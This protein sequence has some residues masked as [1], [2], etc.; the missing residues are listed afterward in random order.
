VSS[1]P[2]RKNTAAPPATVKTLV[3]AVHSRLSRARVAFGH[4]TTNAWDEA[5]YLVLHALRLPLDDLAP[6][7]E[8]KVSS[9]GRRR[10][11]RLVD[12]RIRRRVPA[13]YLT[14]EA[15]LGDYRFYVDAR[16]LV[17]RSFIAELLRERLQPWLARRRILRA[18]DLCTGSGC[19]AVILA[20]VFPS[21]YVDA[22]DISR[23]ALAV[24]RRNV[25]AYRLQRRVRVLRSDMFSALRGE[26]Y[27]LIIANPPYVS[28]N[29]M[30]KLPRE[31]RHEPRVALA[32]GKD[33]FDLLRV[34]LRE[35]AQHL[36]AGGLLVVEVGHKRK[37]IERL[38]PHLAFAWP[39]TSGGDDCVFMLVRGDLT[40]AARAATE[41]PLRA[42]RA[43]GGSRRR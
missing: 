28:A 20:T 27:D 33:G 40:G 25:N 19:L 29:V 4:G 30:R 5:V 14:R 8:Y 12:A 37:Q 32:G 1:Q 6:V 15:W 7:L 24:A 31:Y 36:T 13:A 42:S 26:R 34:I 22:V 9:A 35:S 41:A 21:A 3:D 2:R 39:Q 23:P 10:A 18:L 38:F 17:P 16:A 43:G 11:L